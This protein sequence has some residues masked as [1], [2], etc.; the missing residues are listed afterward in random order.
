MTSNEIYK[1]LFFEKNKIDYNKTIMLTQDNLMIIIGNAK[2]HR[3]QI[4]VEAIQIL[5][6]P[7]KK[8]L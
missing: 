3:A 8:T 4:C 5:W 7:M 6:F 2:Q 1:I